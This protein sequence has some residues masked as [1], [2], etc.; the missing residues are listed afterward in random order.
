MECPV[1][2]IYRTPLYSRGVLTEV[3]IAD[4]HFGV[5]DPK[6]QYKILTEQFLMKIDNIHFDILFIND[7]G[8]YSS[9]FVV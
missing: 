1:S 2:R 5:I 8:K 4:I 3:H 6:V 7:D 9:S